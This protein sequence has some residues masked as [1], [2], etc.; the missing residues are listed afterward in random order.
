MFCSYKDCL[1]QNVKWNHNAPN[2][3]NACYVFQDVRIVAFSLTSP[4]TF[5]ECTLEY[6]RVPKSIPTAL[7]CVQKGANAALKRRIFFYFEGI[8][9]YLTKLVLLLSGHFVHYYSMP[10]TPST[11]TGISR[12]THLSSITDYRL[13]WPM[14]EIWS[15]IQPTVHNVESI[16]MWHHRLLIILSSRLGCSQQSLSCIAA[17]WSFTSNTLHELQH[18]ATCITTFKSLKGAGKVQNFKTI[19]RHSEVNLCYR[20]RGKTKKAVTQLLLRHFTI[21]IIT[22]Y[23]SKHVDSR[24]SVSARWHRCQM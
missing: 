13:K 4:S 23:H 14:A 20:G 17:I 11:C 6:I 8:S 9:G 15:C 1:W 18:Y 5:S 24:P 3:S 10:D 21:I 7:N 16:D 19:K 2:R 22:K 12:E